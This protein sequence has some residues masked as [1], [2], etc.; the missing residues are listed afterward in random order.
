MA[1]ANGRV[2]ACWLVRLVLLVIAVVLLVKLVVLVLAGGGKRTRDRRLRATLQRRVRR[3]HRRLGHDVHRLHVRVARTLGRDVRRIRSMLRGGVVA[4]KRLRERGFSAVTH[5]RRVLLGSARGH[6]SS[7]QLVMRRGLRGALGRHVKRSFRVIQSRLRGIRGKLKRVGSLT[8]SMKKLGGILDGMGVQN[9]FNRMRLKTLLRR[10]VDPRR[11][12]TGIGAGGDKARF[13]RFT[14]GLPNG[15]STGDAMCLPVSTGFPGSIC[16][17]CCSTFRTKSAMLVRS[18]KGRLRGAVGGVT[19]SVR[20][21]CISPPCAASFTVLFLPFRDVCTRIVHH[22][23]LMRVLRG[24]CG[25]MVAKPAALNT[26]LGDLRVNFHA[27]TV[28]GEAKR[29]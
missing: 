7:V 6:L 20:S 24:R 27:L 3:G 26:V 4:A 25:V 23:T 22:A 8:R 12:S 13:I 28:R 21:G 17:R 14:V 9:A 10:V 29:M 16:R 18:S 19:G 5:R 2:L 11:C 1:R 15:S